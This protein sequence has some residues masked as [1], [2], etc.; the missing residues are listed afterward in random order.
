MEPPMFPWRIWCATALLA[1]VF[2]SFPLTPAVP[3][4]FDE[5]LIVEYGCGHLTGPPQ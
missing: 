1:L 3:V 2:F 4:W 5:S